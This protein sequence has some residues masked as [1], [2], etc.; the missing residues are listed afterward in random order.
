MIEVG[1]E[2]GMGEVAEIVGR[3]LGL[4]GTQEIVNDEAMLIF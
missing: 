1:P 3:L 4:Q 2:V